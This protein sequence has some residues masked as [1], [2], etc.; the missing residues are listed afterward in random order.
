MFKDSWGRAAIEQ[1]CYNAE[2]GNAEHKT[3]CRM[4]LATVV[5]YSL[6]NGASIEKV[7]SSRWAVRHLGECLNKN[8]EYEPEPQPSS[9]DD[10]FLDRCRFDSPEDA[11]MALDRAIKMEKAE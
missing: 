9:R 11:Y 7:A 3:K 4:R 8:G 2:R 5:K 10:G 1:E 6:P